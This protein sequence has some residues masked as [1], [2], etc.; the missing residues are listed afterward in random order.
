MP[1]HVTS[2]TN[3]T[4]AYKQQHVEQGRRHPSPS[5]WRATSSSRTG[6]CWSQTK[7][8]GLFWERTVWNIIVTSKHNLTVL[9]CVEDFGCL[10]GMG[11]SGQ[12]KNKHNICALRRKLYKVIQFQSLSIALLNPINIF[13]K[14]F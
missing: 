13:P 6:S 2:I 12:S 14:I 3:L 11:Y 1:Q 7:S 4:L 10:G 5:T 9:S 8:F